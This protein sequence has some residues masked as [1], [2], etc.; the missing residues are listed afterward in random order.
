M[1]HK[2][3]PTYETTDA[4]IVNNMQGATRMCK[5]LVTA[6]V[7]FTV[8]PMPDDLWYFYVKEEAAGIADALAYAAN[9]GGQEPI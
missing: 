9:T 2:S 3:K 4:V 7:F 1:S 5:M 8:E 6:S